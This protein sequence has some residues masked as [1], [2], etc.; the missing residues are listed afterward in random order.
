MIKDPAAQNPYLFAEFQLDPLRRV[1]LRGGR[2]VALNPKAV[3]VLLAMVERR[4]EVVSKDDLLKAVWPD[5]IVEENN[6]T[7]HVSALRK[8]LGEKRGA[9]Q[10]IVTI[11]GYGYRFVADVRRADPADALIV[12]HHSVTH[13]TVEE[14]D[15]DSNTPQTVEAQRIYESPAALEKSSARSAT[16]KRRAV[17]VGAAAAIVLAL[18]VGAFYAYRP[19]GAK[20][21]SNEFERFE[22]KRQTNTGKVLVAVVSPDGQYVAYAQT[23]SDGQSLWLKHVPTGS[24]SRIVEPKP[25]EFWGLTF[26]PDGHYIY[27]TTFEKSQ[28]NPVLTKIPVLGG[29][30]ERLPVVTNGGVS[31][32]PDGRRMA[33]VV[34]SRSSGGSILW[35]AGA[36]GSDKKFIALRKDPNS[37]AMQANT[38]AWSPDGSRIACAVLNNSGDGLY[39]NVVGYGVQDGSEKQLTT[40]RWNFID[41]VAWASRNETLLLTGNDR[42]SVASQVWFVPVGGGGQAR[43]VTHDLNNYHGVSMTN[44]GGSFVTVQTDTTSG[45]WTAQLNEDWKATGFRQNFSE[46]GEIPAIGWK[47]S[48]ELV[49]LSVASGAPEL[50]LLEAESGRARQLTI[51]ARASDFAL[52]PDGRYI[53]VV[54]KRAGKP[55]LWRMDADGGI[56]Q[57]T[58]GDGELRP[59]F[60]SDGQ[61]VFFQ[62]GFGN[63]LS[64]IWKV[65]IDV[66]GDPQQL[67]RSHQTYPDVSPDGTRLVYSF[68][69]TSANAAGQWRLGVAQVEDGKQLASFALPASVTNRLT[70]WTPDGRG[71][72]FIST[73]GG[74]SNLWLQPADGARARQ[75]T[76]FSSQEIETFDLSREGR[77]LAVVRMHT[78]SDAVLLNNTR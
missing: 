69:D 1:L 78:A 77:G 20:K 6:L 62:K 52:S 73:T 47:G 35:T 66:G 12:E 59:R 9:H 48:G 68:M 64:S 63:V 18:A 57:L 7:V 42:Q 15:D 30:T 36:D 13:I 61:F 22:I 58:G 5:Q 8:A 46:I 50:W 71:L 25:V 33:Y 17:Q 37:F 31:F 14:D 26:T 65:S 38:V 75:V 34:S 53:V 3:E 67:T 74:V 40:G 11:P 19:Y 16:K 76:D 56:K 54:S 51:D 24:G 43:R 44:G 27:A 45:I 23:G 72:I 32:S 39:M 4:A 29:V 10:F 41:G 49:Y 55:N 60:A 28:A 21:V 2:P 70:R